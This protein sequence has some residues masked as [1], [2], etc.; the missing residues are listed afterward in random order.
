MLA[1]IFP[2]PHPPRDINVRR[3]ILDPQPIVQA[4]LSRLVRIP[5]A[6]VAGLE[7]QFE[8]GVDLRRGEFLPD[9][10]LGV[11]AVDFQRADFAGLGAVLG[12]DFDLGGRRS[13]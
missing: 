5:R 1:A 11:V 7:T 13:A 8:F 4:A 2:L 10:L 12:E 3:P 9:V 6:R